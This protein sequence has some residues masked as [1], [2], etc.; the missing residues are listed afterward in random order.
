[1][2]YFVTSFS[3]IKLGKVSK[4]DHSLTQNYLSYFVFSLL[5]FAG[6]LVGCKN[7]EVEPDEENES[8]SETY[9]DTETEIETESTDTQSD[10]DRPE[11][12]KSP[13]LSLADADAQELFDF[14]QVPVFDLYLPEDE[15]E[16]LQAN[17]MQEQYTEADACFNGRGIGKVG[18]RFKGSYGTLYECFE[19][20][21]LVCPRLSMKLKFNKYDESL[22]FFGLKRLNFN[23]NRYDDSRMKER[24]AYD[25][26]REMGIIA[27]R[28]AWAVVK[29]N[30]QSYGLYGMVE[31]IDGRFTADRWSDY[32][33]GNLYKELWPTDTNADTAVS[34]L[35]TNE[36]APDVNSFVKF[37]EDFTSA[38][39]EDLMETLGKYM[40]LDHWARYMAVD[41]AILSYDGIIYFWT[42]GVTRH[43]HNYYIY[44]D[45]PGHFTLIPWDVESSFWINPDHAAPHWTLLP[46]D[47]NQT[48]P[49]WGGLASAPGCDPV[50]KAINTDRS[51]WRAAVR[52]LLDG[53]F[54]VDKMTETIDRYA[55][56]IGEEARKPETPTMYGTFDGTI[57]YLKSQ[58]PELRKRLENLLAADE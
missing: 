37:A 34:A 44:E 50:F 53:P 48:Y 57:P 7:V 3:V 8:S 33:D 56:L 58:I 10:D 5:L 27:P 16:L 25:L 18:L 28:A 39:E 19:G 55:E 13:D 41:E 52:E 21:K 47:C 12:L 15:W 29:V 20:G 9:F 2:S 26:Y 42:D 11:C 14:D 4:T 1:M 22:R 24:L 51:A 38:D 6:L 32:P 36:E 40:D 46:E 54:A 45:K 23:A 49:Y 30:G 17:A 35:R 43:N 31:Q